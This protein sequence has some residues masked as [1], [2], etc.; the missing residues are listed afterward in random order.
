MDARVRACTER[1]IIA[2][3]GG[4]AGGGAMMGGDNFTIYRGFS[5]F[6]LICCLNNGLEFVK[7]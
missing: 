6:D 1:R 5:F 2:K 3:H 4:G 7:F